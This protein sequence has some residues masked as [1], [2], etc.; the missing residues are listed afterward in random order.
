MTDQILDQFFYKDQKLDLVGIEG[1]SLI[2]IQD[3]NIKTRSA[4]SACWRGYVMRYVITDGQLILDGIWFKPISEELPKINCIAPVLISK[5]ND[6]GMGWFFTH[7]YKKLNKIITFNGS[8]LIKKHLTDSQFGQMGFMNTNAHRIV[9]K[10][11]F[12]DGIIVNVEDKSEQVEKVREEG[13]PNGYRPDSMAPK[14]LDD[15]IMKRLSL[16]PPSGQLKGTTM[17]KSV[18]EEMLDELD[19]LKKL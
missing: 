12:E 15:W 5:E 19:R 7:A 10:F 1:S 9:L 16:N 11:D 6:P 8:I 14:D 17:V 18:E 3:F 2:T 13:D 4:S